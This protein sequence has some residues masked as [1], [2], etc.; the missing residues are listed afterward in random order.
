ME[1]NREQGVATPC[2]KKGGKLCLGRSAS[3]SN[4]QFE[5]LVKVLIMTENRTFTKSSKN[6]KE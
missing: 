3:S 6:K 4:N 5:E 2:S 1:L